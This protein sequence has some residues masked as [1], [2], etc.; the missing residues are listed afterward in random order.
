MQVKIGT[1]CAAFVTMSAFAG[2]N[3][4]I[5]AGWEFGE[6]RVDMLLSRADAMDQTP[7][8]GCVINLW[9]KNKAGQTITSRGII[10]QPLWDYSD[11]EPLIPEYRKLLSHKS[12]RSSFLGFF[13]A[14]KVRLSWSDDS[15]WL[16]LSHNMRLAARFA[17]ACGFVGLQMDPEDYHL[18]QQFSL[19]DADNMAYEKAAELARSRGCQIFTGVFEEFPDA[20]ILSYFL[21]SMVNTYLGDVDGRC[22]RDYMFRAGFDLWPHFVEGMF[23][24]LPPTA[25]LIEGNESA[26]SYRARRMEYYR[27]GNH[28]KNNLGGLLTPENQV[29]YRMQVQNSFGVY[30]DGYSRH[31]PGAPFGYYME[32][33][34]GSRVR[35]LGINMKQSVEV[36]DEFIWFWGEKGRWVDQKTNTWKSWKDMMPGLY[37]TLLSLKSPAELGRDI[38]LKMEKGE[39]KN[40]V[41]NSTCEADDSASVPKPYWSWQDTKKKFRQGVFG[42]DLTLGCGDKSS[43]VAEGV[44][45]GCFVCDVNGRRPGEIVGISF[46][47]KGKVSVQ[48]GWKKNGKWDWNIPGVFVPVVGEPD[49]DGWIRTDWS[50]VV[51]DGADGLGLRLGVKQCAGEKSWFDNV[52]AIPME[53]KKQEEA[54]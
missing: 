33:I 8:D 12:F 38:R 51:P 21:L 28:V 49:A 13:H 20:K 44:G 30:L 3:K 1:V 39:L 24:A 43:L 6:A 36:A 27:V 54:K 31:K 45:S 48:V 19:V 42:T 34:D 10:Q 52:M 37:E 5:A 14:P 25:I 11:I 7:V 4:F 22:L 18:Q 17:K 35:H 46:S 15:A 29:K 16:K 23:D 32:P 40:V 26:Y 2:A 53:I 50:I 47:S 9:A 41:A